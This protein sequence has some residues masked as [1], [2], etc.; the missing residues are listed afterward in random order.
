MGRDLERALLKP[1]VPETA[2]P[3]PSLEQGFIAILF[4][5]SRMEGVFIRIARG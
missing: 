5:L 4:F 2:A 1:R 3:K